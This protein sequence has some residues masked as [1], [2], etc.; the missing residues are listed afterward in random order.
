M[1]RQDRRAEDSRRKRE[2][3]IIL[4]RADGGAPLD[5]SISQAYALATETWRQG[6]A[7]EAEI[8]YR[9]LLRVDPKH[10]DA[11][12]NLGAIAQISGRAELAIA[13][14]EQA[15]Q[16]A[17]DGQPTSA[18]T[19]LNYG[20][21]LRSAGR[22]ADAIQAYGRGLEVDPDMAALHHNLG[23]IL[24]GFGELDAALASFRN[25]VHLEPGDASFWQGYGNCMAL[26]GAIP[27]DPTYGNEIA[28]CLSTP[29]VE[30]QILMRCAVAYLKQRPKMQVA[31]QALRDG[32]LVLDGV[33]GDIL[34]SNLTAACLIYDV[35]R[36]AE[37]EQL[38]TAVRR[39]YLLD[40]G[41]RSFA[42]KSL[43]FG[44]GMQCFLNEYVY[45]ETPQ[46]TAAVDALISQLEN[47]GMDQLKAEPLGALARDIAI[48]AAYRPLHQQ[49]F[50]Q[51]L[52][53]ISVGAPMA[54]LITR[55]IEEPLD[56][57]KLRGTVK[58]LTAI[59]EE[60][61]LRVQAQYEENPYPRWSNIGIGGAVSV[62]VALITRFP[63]LQ[64]RE[65]RHPETPRILV[66]GCGTGFDAI[67]I[68]RGIQG[69]QVT[70]ID[71]SLTSLAYAKRKANEMAVRNIE[72]YQG[73]ILHLPETG[74]QFD[75][76]QAFGVL[77]H[78]RDPLHGWRIL[79]QCLHPSGL[80]RI[81]LY[82][83]IARAPVVAARELI[84]QRGFTPDLTGMRECRST[85][86][87][88]PAGHPA[89]SV[90]REGSDFYTASTCRDL[91]FHTQEHRFTCLQ[92]QQ[93]IDDLGL[94]FLGFEFYSAAARRGY[95]ESFPD[96]V[97]M[98]NLAN[99]HEYEKRNPATFTGTDPMWLRKPDA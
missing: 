5:L 9:N 14:L 80:M 65:M 18:E 22:V 25:A 53:Q 73:D 89:K 99:W 81:A 3:R 32:A 62:G 24:Q 1:N 83:E 37:L 46:E 33:A 30:T 55:Q 51:R 34:D 43:L 76:I 52:L 45:E 23:A 4:H 91:L 56:E 13:L 10:Q 11:L 96:D 40:A 38:F 78:M 26:R 94:E 16:G 8:I 7:A 58:K 6:R 69:A 47:A 74:R 35:A 77:H 86:M 87:D 21:A 72:F 41:A 59:D 28:V 84:A 88:L 42:P 90:M 49:N 39:R 97:E 27:D 67:G 50:A 95:A 85:I 61:S 57:K 79:N 15:L 64:G 12:T 82:S 31:L 54:A 60:T 44:L 36:D 93:M 66:A 71:L 17:S 75:F 70:A 63:H 98:T 48:V 19:W 2:K 68:A 20:A 29:G 92:R